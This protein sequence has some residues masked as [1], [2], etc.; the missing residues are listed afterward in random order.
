MRVID[1]PLENLAI[2]LKE[3]GPAWFGLSHH[4]LDRLLKQIGVDRALDPQE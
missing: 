2:H 1:H 4:L 3:R